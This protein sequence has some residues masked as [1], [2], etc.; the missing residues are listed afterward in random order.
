LDLTLDLL[1]TYRVVINHPRDGGG[2]FDRTTLL[3]YTGAVLIYDKRLNI[4]MQLYFIRHA[5][6]ENNALWE[7]TGDNKGRSEDPDLTPIGIQQ[8]QILSRYLARGESDKVGGT[9]DSQNSAGFGISHL[10]SSLMVRAVMTGIH[11]ARALDLPLVAWPDWH[12]SGGIYLED[13]DSGEPIGLPG[14][15][16]AYFE[17]F[18]PELLLSEDLGSDGW[19]NRPFETRAQRHERA[20]RVLTTLWQR[21]GNKTDRV[22]IISHGGF[23]NYFLSALFD[24]PWNENDLENDS[25]NDKK[26][27]SGR[28]FQMNN[29]SIS[30][31][32]IDHAVQ[33]VYHNRVDFLPPNLVT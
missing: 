21:H 29:A 23:Y 24:L 28:W 3:G 1:S 8:A 10:Y 4:T 20:L 12:E 26:L 27:P 7:R 16:R 9:W 13:R 31:I 30:R 2:N 22:A 15:N 25:Q 32:D 18:F 5:Q 19:W 17:R 14:K 11:L 6:S 33:L